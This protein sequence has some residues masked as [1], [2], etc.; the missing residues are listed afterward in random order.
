LRVRSV[1]SEYSENVTAQL[2]NPRLPPVAHAV[3]DGSVMQT[4]PRRLPLATPAPSAPAFV[5]EPAP[6]TKVTPRL[7]E[8]KAKVFVHG[9]R[10]APE[11][12]AEIT[13][14]NHYKHKRAGLSQGRFLRLLDGAAHTAV[15]A[16]VLEP[17]VARSPLR[18][19]RENQGYAV[20]E[21]EA[22][23]CSC[24]PFAWPR[25][26]AR[27]TE[28]GAPMSSVVS[29]LCD[30]SLYTAIYQG[31]CDYWQGDQMCAFC[32]MKIDQKA[33]WRSVESIIEV[34]RVALDENPAAEISFGGGTRLAEDKSARHK[35]DAIEVFKRA[36]DMRVCV[37]MAAPD[38]DDWLDRLKDA[39]LDSIL[40]NLEL[41]GEDARRRIMPGKSAIT[42][43]RYLA[44][45][46]YAVKILGE[47]QVSSQIIV[48][49]E[50]IDDTMRAIEAV[51]DAGAIPMPV[52]FRPLPGT[53]LEDVAP[54]SVDDVL[55][56]FTRTHALLERRR[57]SGHA[58]R[59]G[60]ALCGACS[61]VS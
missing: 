33:K 6:R 9:L 13:D 39:G 32:A 54:P 36:V 4:T 44:A 31:G 18:L 34:A 57:M 55:D 30:T 3:L 20:Y 25:W 21:G 49:L 11:L 53:A 24:V 56:V 26:Y 14:E 52:V 16:P 38:T 45:L 41:W 37:E 61:G 19:E 27:H 15:N 10:V 60:C 48:G 22:R 8:L 12:W 29:A 59:S 51:A 47:N 2:S 50:P 17:F 35:A 5:A 40:M 42:R 1:S 43:E 46:A 58:A 23:L 7:L 28:S